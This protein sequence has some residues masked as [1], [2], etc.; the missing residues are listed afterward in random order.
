MVLSNLTRLTTLFILIRIFDHSTYGSE[1]DL[2]PNE[3]CESQ[4][5]KYLDQEVLFNYQMDSVSTSVGNLG[6]SRYQLRLHQRKIIRENCFKSWTI[7]VYMAAN[8]NLTQYA[9]ADVLKMEAFSRFLPG[10]TGSSKKIDVLVEI[11]SQE[12]PTELRRIHIFQSEDFSLEELNFEKIKALK[13]NQ[14]RSPITTLYNYRKD[15]AYSEKIIEFLDWGIQ[16]YPSKHYLF[17]FWGHGQGWTAIPCSNSALRERMMGGIGLRETEIGIEYLSIPSLKKIL[18]FVSHKI[19]KKVDLLVTDA[20][21]MQSIETLA[22]LR[23]EARFIC[24]SEEIESFT[25][26]PYQLLFRYMNQLE[27]S[28]Q[29][30]EMKVLEL[31]KVIPILYKESI[32]FTFGCQK[33]FGSSAHWDLIYSTI[34]TDYLMRD[35]LPAIDRLGNCLFEYVTEQ[36]EKWMELKAFIQKGPHHLG[37]SQDLGTFLERLM[38]FATLE[39]ARQNGKSSMQNLESAVQ[40]TYLALKKSLTS[41]ILGNKYQPSQGSKGETL[42]GVSIWLPRTDQEFIDRYP[43]FSQSW[44]YQSHSHNQHSGW[45][46]WMQ[47]I[48]PISKCKSI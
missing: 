16:N 24:G 25:G 36:D 34:E 18:S 45:K 40:Q 47:M 32:D 33:N 29:S 2:L 48:Y 6:Y 31:A 41:C 14:I 23:Q 3:S 11:E 13:L 37:G 42:K 4:W 19:G 12:N 17:L 1:R 10:Q 44:L 30:E 43:D 8:N 21:L 35:L 38:Q 27:Q 9:L 15:L 5:E 26:L 46:K 20:C 28:E 7:L 22:E 39:N